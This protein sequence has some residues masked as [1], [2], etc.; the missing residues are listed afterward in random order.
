MINH[1]IFIPL[2]LALVIVSILFA[3]VVIIKKQNPC[4]TKVLAVFYSL[5]TIIVGGY[6]C[7]QYLVLTPQQAI[8]NFQPLVLISVFGL[9]LYNVVKFFKDLPKLFKE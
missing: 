1:F 4:Y 9:I 6:F 3:Y 8:E 5:A 2:F 7:Y